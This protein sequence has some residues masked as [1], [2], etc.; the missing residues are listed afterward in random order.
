MRANARIVAERLCLD[1]SPEAL[2]QCHDRLRPPQAPPRPFSMAAQAV[3]SSATT[4]YHGYTGSKQLFILFPASSG[5]YQFSR[6]VYS[7][8]GICDLH[9]SV[10]VTSGSTGGFPSRGHGFDFRLCIVCGDRGDLDPEAGDLYL[11]HHQ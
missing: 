6:H 4:I 1:R 10:D 9:S 8:H 2:F 11:I 3:V 7:C 5:G